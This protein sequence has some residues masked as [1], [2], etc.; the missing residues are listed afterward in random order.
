LEKHF[1]LGNT[2]YRCFPQGE[3][4]EIGIP[5]ERKLSTSSQNGYKSI[6]EALKA[7][8]GR[9]VENWATSLSRSSFLKGKDFSELDD[10]R[11]DRMTKF[12]TALIEKAETPDSKRA[13]ETL[14]SAIR[15]EIAT[16]MGATAMVKKQNMLRDAMLQVVERDLQNMSRATANLAIGAMIDRSIETIVMM[17]EDYSELRRSLEQ[18]MPGA[19]DTRF[20]LDQGFSRFCKNVM[21]YFEV[22]FVALFQYLPRTRE[23][24]C[25]ACSAK[26]ISL[27]KGST[28]LLDSFPMAA[29]AID[30]RKTIV[31]SG[32][33]KD[34]PKKKVIGRLAFVNSMAVPLVRGEEVMGLM[35]L[36]DSSKATAFTSEEVSLMEDIAVQ[37]VWV[38]SSIALFSQLSVRTKAQKALIETAAALQQEISS[39]EIYRIVATKLSEIVPCNEIQFYIYDWDRRIGNPVYATGPYTSEIMADR[40]FPADIGIAGYVARSRKAEIIHD[41]EKDPRGSVIPGTPLNT[42]RMLAVPL[43]GQKEVLGVIE[44]QRYPPADFTQEDLET[45]IMFANHASVALENAKL[46]QELRHARD[47]IEVHMDLL[48]HDIANYTTPIMAYFESLRTRQD[49]DPQ[50]ASVVDRT[51]RQVESMMR[52][53]DMVRTIARLREADRK[54][55]RSMDVKKA[56]EWAIAEIRDRAHRD[57][58]EFELSLPEEPVLV[59]AD[60]ML[61]EIFLNLFNSVAMPDKETKTKLLVSMEPRRDR[62]TEYWWIRVA[63]P[64]RPI[65]NN[66]KGEVLRMSK[67]SKSEL[68]GGFGIGLAAAKGVVDRYAGNM[69]V[70]DIVQGD[71]TKGCVFNIMLPRYR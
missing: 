59:L 55:F 39:E 20:S 15:A 26:G 51:S 63:Q 1:I 31:I 62:K 3:L 23:T 25:Q 61:R 52:L 27:T 14:K 47:Q 68:T 65:P 50:I 43:I 38:L 13:S 28:V 4:E 2:S 30:K 46:L 22:D 42:T 21:D 29:E 36:G 40:D 44:L 71:Y 70:S 35:L 6:L 45:A 24:V 53:V 64:S 17:L 8:T 34:P 49:L 60:D 41:T 66:L 12:V 19:P 57:D 5:V 18:C 58:I 16:V 11:L 48:T 33:E 7:N 10:V 56:L 37:L 32:D 54:A 69:W 67:S 9:I